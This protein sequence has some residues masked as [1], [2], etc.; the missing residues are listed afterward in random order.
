MRSVAAYGL[1]PPG[2]GVIVTADA[3]LKFFNLRIEF[4]T[5]VSTKTVAVIC[6]LLAAR[7]R[8]CTWYGIRYT[9]IA[10]RL[11]LPASIL[12]IV[13][14]PTLGPSWGKSTGQPLDIVDGLLLGLCAVAPTA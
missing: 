6:E 9:P 12:E 2:I 10:A 8:P 11:K 5:V 7:R 1:T 3:L 13:E 14:S 4:T